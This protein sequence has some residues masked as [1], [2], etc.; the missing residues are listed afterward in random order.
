MPTP[1][2]L[3]KES[4]FL[5]EEVDKETTLLMKQ[6]LAERAVELALLAEQIERQKRKS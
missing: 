1:S 3:R 2:D 5:R 4:Q 6:K